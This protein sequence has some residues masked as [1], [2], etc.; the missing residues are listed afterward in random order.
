MTCINP[1]GLVHPI[2]WNRAGMIKGRRLSGRSQCDTK[3]DP[4]TDTRANKSPM[5]KT[6]TQYH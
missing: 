3:D 2:S 5:D 6:I 1:R 4:P